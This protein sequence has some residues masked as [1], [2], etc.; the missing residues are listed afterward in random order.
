MPQVSYSSLLKGYEPKTRRPIDTKALI[1]C[2]N[3]L[4]HISVQQVWAR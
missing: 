2:D 1:I 3:V 4:Y